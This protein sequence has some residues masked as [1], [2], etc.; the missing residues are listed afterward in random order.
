MME[1]DAAPA[2]KPR[3]LAPGRLRDPARAALGP[4]REVLRWTGTG[5][6]RLVP[7]NAG[8]ETENAAGGAPRGAVSPIAR[9]SGH[10]SQSVSGGFAGRSRGAIASAPA[11]PGAPLP[12]G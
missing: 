1:Q 2:G 11:F 9:R 10:A 7:G 8:P 4:L 3:K 12:S 6:L 5:A